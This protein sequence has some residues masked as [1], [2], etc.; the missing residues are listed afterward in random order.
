MGQVRV[1]RSYDYCHFEIDLDYPEGSSLDEVNERR[2]EAALLVDEAVRQY[3]IAKK[4]ES[5]REY[6]QRDVETALKRVDAIKEKPQSE[7]SVEEA[8]LMRAYEDKS[9]WDSIEQDVY[10]YEEYD[11]EREYHFSMLRRFQDTRVVPF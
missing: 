8:A 9:F 6:H 7:W 10:C 2:K 11:P 4:A 1:M 5:Q 3:K